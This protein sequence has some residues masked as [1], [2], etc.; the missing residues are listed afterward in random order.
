M[1]SEAETS[2]I[3][4][5]RQP[6]KD[7]ER[8]FDCVS[9]SRNLAQNDRSKMATKQTKPEYSQ[10]LAGVIAGETEICWVD[11]DAGLAYRGYDSREM[12]EQRSF[13][14][15]AYLLRKVDLHDN[16]PQAQFNVEHA[17]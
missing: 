11:T 16:T 2:L 17:S 6:R 8:F 12:A 5:G 1:L 15:V 3:V 14:E 13:E 7:S 9:L 4:S 10:G